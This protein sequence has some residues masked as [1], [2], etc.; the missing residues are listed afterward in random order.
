[1]PQGPTLSIVPA[2]Y[3]GYLR[4]LRGA[5]SPCFSLFS[6]HNVNISHKNPFIFALSKKK[7][8]LC[9]EN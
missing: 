6:M 2:L 5:K 8:Y 9:G 3:A 7:L 4:P 1:M